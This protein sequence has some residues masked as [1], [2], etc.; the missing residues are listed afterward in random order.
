MN[1]ESIYF[2]CS[3]GYTERIVLSAQDPLHE[4]CG[5]RNGARIATEFSGV[6]TTLVCGIICETPSE[7]LERNALAQDED[8][9]EAD[10]RL[11]RARQ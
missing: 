3:T 11:V 5:T 9:Q 6:F 8:R 10:I 4:Y 1:C 7:L 2:Q